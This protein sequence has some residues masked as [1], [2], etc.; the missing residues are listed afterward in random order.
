[1]GRSL[2]TGKNSARW[3]FSQPFIAAKEHIS[4]LQGSGHTLCR[5]GP[6]GKPVSEGARSGQKPPRKEP[7]FAADLASE[8]KLSGLL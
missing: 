5:Q 3:I 1:M 6:P 4:A 8:L 2:G 7:R